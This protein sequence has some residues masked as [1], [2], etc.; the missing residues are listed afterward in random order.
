MVSEAPVATVLIPAH[1]HGALLGLA[2]QST[3][4]QTVEALEVFI[5]LDGADDATRTVATKTASRDGRVRVFDFPKGERH[6]EAHRDVVLAEARGSVVCYLSDDDLWF[7]DHVEQMVEMR[8]L[9]DCASGRAGFHRTDGSLETLA[10]DLGDPVWRR[11]LLRD[12]AHNFFG[13]SQG[14]HTIEAYRALPQ[15]WHPAPR[16]LP[17]DL[18]MW[19][20]FLEDPLISA[21]S[22]RSATVF[23]FP[24]PARAGMR[25]S[26]RYEEMSAWSA[27]LADPDWVSRFRGELA[28]IIQKGLNEIGS[29][30]MAAKV[31]LGSAYTRISE[32]DAANLA[33]KQALDDAADELVGVQRDLQDA[34]DELEGTRQ[35]L[36][37]AQDALA[38]VQHQLQQ[39]QASI[40]YRAARRLA[41]IPMLRWVGRLVGVLLAGRRT[42]PGG[43]ERQPE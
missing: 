1:A 21:T 37:G 18:H 39:V 29:G 5:V 19:R 32:L 2:T 34:R 42:D 31:D 23:T 36:Q 41:R 9:A 15:G 13:L 16:D 22:A 33:N 26:D 35:E 24:S 38:A 3:L 12:P 6:G 17:T 14:G 40:S 25:L 4:S 20:H 11:R 27:R 30:L 8:A 43:A 28:P 7:P 10:G